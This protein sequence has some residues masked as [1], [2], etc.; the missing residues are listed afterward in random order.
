MGD[1]SQMVIWTGFT[2]SNIVPCDDEAGFVVVDPTDLPPVNVVQ[3][4]AFWFADCDP[5]LNKAVHDLVVC[6]LPT[7]I[8][9]IVPPLPPGVAAMCA[10]RA[11]S[12]VSCAVSSVS[13]AIAAAPEMLALK[14]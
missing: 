8:A 2:S 10:S 5:V 6:V 14:P 1:N 11:Y 4:Q 13:N 9:S 12:A 3:E 7:G